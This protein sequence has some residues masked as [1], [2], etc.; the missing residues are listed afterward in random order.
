[1]SVKRWATMRPENRGKQSEALIPYSSGAQRSRLEWKKSKHGLKLVTILMAHPRR[2]VRVKNSRP[3]LTIGPILIAHLVGAESWSPVVRD[4][5]L[6][7]LIARGVN[8][9][10]KAGAEANVA[11]IRDPSPKKRTQDR[12]HP[13]EHM[14]G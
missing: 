14:A 5:Y 6:K 1:M 3:A 11:I 7:E 10:D 4:W 8:V 13:W 12:P 9:D 2:N